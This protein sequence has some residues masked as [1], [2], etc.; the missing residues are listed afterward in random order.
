[1]TQ[2]E[3]KTPSYHKAARPLTE[4][5][6][7]KVDEPTSLDQIAYSVNENE[8]SPAQLATSATLH[9]L[10]GCGVGEIAGDALGT[11]LNLS[12][13]LTI[14]LGLL[15]GL[16][17]GFGLGILPLRRRGIPLGAAA[18]IVLISEGLSI[19]VMEATEASVEVFVPGLMAATLT[20][21]F[22]WFGMA[23]ALIAGFLAA[24]P[25]NYALVRRGVTHRH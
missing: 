15:F 1:V 17:G 4:G 22:Y 12:N 18:R 16:I 8:T 3:C 14:G 10:A 25:V 7:V 20:Q 11:G 24:W 2:S 6:Q 19:A 9:C 23:G 5:L 21:A 13:R